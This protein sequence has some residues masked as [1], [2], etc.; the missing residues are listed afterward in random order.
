MR[1]G[2]QGNLR[3]IQNENISILKKHLKY[4]EI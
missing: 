3:K 4:F 1:E 2:N